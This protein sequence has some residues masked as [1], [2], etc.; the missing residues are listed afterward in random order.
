MYERTC[1]SPGG[2]PE[3]YVVI[4]SAACPPTNAIS[5]D[6]GS[7]AYAP[8]AVPGTIVAAVERGRP[9]AK[10]PSPHGVVSMVC[11]PTTTLPAAS[12]TTTA[13]LWEPPSGETSMLSGAL[14]IDHIVC[15]PDTMSV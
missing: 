13:E 5:L 15:A 7:M 14:A 3:P 1:T 8:G 9:P 12:T 2:S 6:S 4:A 11:V 10:M